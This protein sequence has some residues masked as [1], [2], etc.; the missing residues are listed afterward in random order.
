MRLLS[1]IL[2]TFLCFGILGNISFSRES[3]AQST[4]AQGVQNVQLPAVTNMVLLSK[5]LYITPRRFEKAARA[6]GINDFSIQELKRYQNT[7]LVYLGKIPF[8]VLNVPQPVPVKT[9]DTVLKFGFGLDNGKSIVSKQRAHVVISPFN[10]PS[11][12]SE[13]IPGA[14]GVA[15]VSAIIGKLQKPLGHYWSHSD[16]LF[17][18][19]QFENSEMAIKKAMELKQKNLKDAGASLPF[20]MWVGFRLTGNMDGGKI[21]ARTLGLE[22]FTGYELEVVP[23]SSKPEVLGH[24]V[25]G[26]IEF[27]FK[28]GPILKNGEALWLGNSEY[29]RLSWKQ[30][31]QNIPARFLMTLLKDNK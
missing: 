6:Y 17:S 19:S 21:G 8:I 4:R 9:F 10:K 26:A 2:V 13:S 18:Q 5:P 22:A 24:Q 16:T 29:F 28:N 25:Y 23:V 14:I 15:Q 11:N 7:Y 27:I 1:I 3:L 20:M 30:A 12:M 31:T